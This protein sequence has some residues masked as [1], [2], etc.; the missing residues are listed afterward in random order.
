M[1][2]MINIEWYCY[3]NQNTLSSPV[4][5]KK[6][7]RVLKLKYFGISALS[8][9]IFVSRCMPSPDNTLLPFPNSGSCDACIPRPKEISTVLAAALWVDGPGTAAAWSDCDCTQSGIFISPRS[10]VG[11]NHFRKMQ[12]VSTCNLN[13]LLALSRSQTAKC[14]WNIVGFTT[15]RMVLV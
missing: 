4:F 1:Y 13:S 11:S 10:K 8:N 5:F 12:L 9:H 2:N 15:R 6:R 3:I 14:F 7:I